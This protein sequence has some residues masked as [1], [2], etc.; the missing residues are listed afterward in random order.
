LSRSTAVLK[1][2]PVVEWICRSKT[3]SVLSGRPMSRLSATRASKKDRAWRGA[4]EQMVLATSTWRME[5][6]HQ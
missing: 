4:A 2:P 6:S 5:M 1:Y 3:I